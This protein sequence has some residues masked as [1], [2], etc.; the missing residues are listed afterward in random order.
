MLDYKKLGLKAGLEIHQQLEGKKLF[1][2]CPT[3]MRDDPPHF[4]VKRYL[5]AT[6][7]ES[8]KIDVAAEQEQKKQKYFLYQGYYDS[9]CLV[10]LD[11]EPPHEINKDALDLGLQVSMLLDANIIEAVQ[12]MR[13][14]VVDGSNTS[15]F[16]RT[17]LIAIDGKIKTKNNLIT[18]SSISIEEDAAKIVERYSDH[19]IY[20]LDRLGIPLI[21]IGTGPDMKTPEEVQEIAAYIGMILRSTGKVKRGLG[22]IRQD[23]NVSIQQGSRVEIK[24]AQDLKTIPL[25]VENEAKRQLALIE[26]RTEL[27]KRKF[28]ELKKVDQINLTNIFKK[29][30]CNFIKKAIDNGNDIIGIKISKFDKLIGKELMPNYRFGTELAGHAKVFGF[31][32][33]IHSDE[34]FEKYKFSEQEISKTK[35][36]LKVKNNDAFILVVGDRNKAGAMIEHALIPRI[37]YA[38]IGVPKEVRNANPD[39]T[40]SYLRPMPGA[41]RMYPETDVPII[42][43]D[44]KHIKMPELINDKVKRISKKY[45]LD[46]ALTENLIKSNNDELFEN[47]IEKLKK[48]TIKVNFI[49]EFLLKYKKDIL[50]LYDKDKN[51]TKLNLDLINENMILNLLEQLSK[52]KLSKQSL[53]HILYD[54]ALGNDFVQAIDKFAL[55]STSKLKKEIQTIISENTGLKSKIKDKDRLNK[56]MLGICMGRLKYNARSED[57][58]KV[59]NQVYK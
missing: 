46:L 15:G 39:A 4:E 47:I 50:E 56:T 52:Q 20:R 13:K 19:N 51:K 54:V 32:G 25:L 45:K 1:C 16:Q 29:T 40:S 18:I 8:G 24:G 59:F 9:T 35:T 49:A 26:L 6:A 10:E 33:I 36:E 41:S 23:V 3:L 7:G 53:N 28:S 57:I 12:V 2:D 22:T 42:F 14:T 55:L 11:E 58:I 31:G 37:N 30:K 44:V 34:N 48:T 27:K 38:L 43:T 21:E 17:A 5:R